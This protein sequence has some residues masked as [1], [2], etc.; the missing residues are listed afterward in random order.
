MFISCLTYIHTPKDKN[1]KIHGDKDVYFDTTCI[2]YIARVRIED[3]D[4]YEIH[5]KSSNVLLVNKHTFKTLR[6]SIT[7]EL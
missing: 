3:E 1:K 5:F 4:Y 2:E 6:K 7:K